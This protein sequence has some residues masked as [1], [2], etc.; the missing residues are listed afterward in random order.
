MDATYIDGLV[1]VVV[2][3]VGF[4]MKYKTRDESMIAA[5]EGIFNAFEKEDDGKQEIASVSFVSRENGVYTLTAT[6]TEASALETIMA[7]YEGFEIDASEFSN[8][9]KVITIECGA[10]GYVVRMAQTLCYTF[11]GE[12]YRES[13]T[14][15][16]VNIGVVPEISAPADADSYMDMDAME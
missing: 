12:V 5:F 1:Y 14:C 11:D 3:S 9:S 10:D 16:Y 13:M 8:I 2:K 7:D 15:N 6:M 4:E